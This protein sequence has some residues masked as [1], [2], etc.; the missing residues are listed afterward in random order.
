MLLLSKQQ[1]HRGS[2]RVGAGSFGVAVGVGGLVD[3]GVGVWVGVAVG[4]GVLV[5]VGVGVWVGVA[6]GVGVPVSVDV[7]VWVGVTV[8]VREGVCVGLSVSSRMI[9]GKASG[10]KFMYR[11]YFLYPV[12]STVNMASF[13]A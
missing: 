8:G 1:P 12:A 5:D 10:I 11:V 3:V 4:V 2:V 7:S 9:S 6:V 13:C